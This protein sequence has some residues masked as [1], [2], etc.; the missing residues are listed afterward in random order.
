MG[1]IIQFNLKDS[2][3]LNFQKTWN[4]YVKS[5]PDKVFLTKEEFLVKMRSNRFID[6]AIAKMES[7]NRISSTQLINSP[8]DNDIG[9]WAN[10]FLVRVPSNHKIHCDSNF[11]FIYKEKINLIEKSNISYFFPTKSVYKQ[12]NIEAYSLDYALNFAIPVTKNDF[13]YCPKCK[14]IIKSNEVFTDNLIYI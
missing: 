8:G 3:S 14:K 9:G 4:L 6:K 10:F 5:K 13:V 1:N 12:L 2:F 11:Y 7:D